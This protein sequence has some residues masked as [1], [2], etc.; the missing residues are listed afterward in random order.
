MLPKSHKAF[1]KTVAQE[2]AIDEN[3]VADVIGFFYSDLR[4]ALVELRDVRLKIPNFGVFTV[5]KKELVKIKEKYEQHLKVLK[6]ETFNQVTLRKDIEVRLDAINRIL[7]KLENERQER[8]EF[9]KMKHEK[10]FSN[11]QQPKTDL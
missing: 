3:L 4:K 10:Y 8:K 6:S 7:E 9:Y 1:I 2:Q 11:P 5:K